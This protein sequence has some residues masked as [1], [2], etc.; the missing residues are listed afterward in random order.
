MATNQEP[1]EPSTVVDSLPHF[2]LTI[3]VTY[4][5]PEPHLESEERDEDTMQ[6]EYEALPPALQKVFWEKEEFHSQF[7]TQ[8]GLA[9]TTKE[10]V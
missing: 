5:I 10:I 3:P 4:Y 2:G 6:R 1:T 7:Q 9:V 8:F